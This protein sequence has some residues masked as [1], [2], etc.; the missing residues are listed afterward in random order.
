M[1]VSTLY[2]VVLWV[3]S[4]VR[5]LIVAA[6]GALMLATALGWRSGK[7]FSLSHERLQ[8][9]LLGLADT[10][11]LLGLGLFLWLSPLAKAFFSA[12]ALGMKTSALRFFGMEHAVGMLVAIGVLHVAHRRSHSAAT[13]S[14]RHR[15]AC[16]G[17]LAFLLLALVSIPWPGNAHG[18]PL[19]RTASVA[20]ATPPS[21]AVRSCPPAYEARCA[22]CH[23][24]RGR[25]D[26]M[27]GRYL[28]PPARNFA[29][30]GFLTARTDADLGAVIREGGASR[31]LSAT[32]PAH[33]DLT[34]RDLTD[35]VA[36]VRSLGQP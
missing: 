14:L 7:A 32:M 19:F 4:Y 21:T 6:A 9:A 8:R 1:L 2:T 30:P 11:F 35:L 12:P 25:G 13:A 23:G 5:W 10:Q 29:E 16:L 28:K 22:A 27:V 26:G 20:A 3:H 15:R 24:D 33:R 17:T 31:G 18:R 34:E 36:C